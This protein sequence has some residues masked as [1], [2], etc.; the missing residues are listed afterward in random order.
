MRSRTCLDIE[1]ST[2]AVACGNWELGGQERHGMRGLEHIAQEMKHP[3]ERHGA[4]PRSRASDPAHLVRVERQGVRACP[5]ERCH[6]HIDGN[7]EPTHDKWDD[8]SF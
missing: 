2:T 5:D 3:A 7:V 6:D 4:T 1:P 8:T